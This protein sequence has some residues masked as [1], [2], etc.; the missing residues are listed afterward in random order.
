MKKIIKQY[1]GSRSMPSVGGRNK[2]ASNG[3]KSRGKIVF[4]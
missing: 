4:T 2:T 1:D 3:W